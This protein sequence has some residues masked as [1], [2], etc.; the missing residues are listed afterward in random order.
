LVKMSEG[1]LFMIINAVGISPH[2]AI[3]C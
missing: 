2:L 3:F 1:R